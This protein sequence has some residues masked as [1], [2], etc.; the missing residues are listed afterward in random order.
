MEVRRMNLFEGATKDSKQVS[1]NQRACDQLQAAMLK[2]CGAYVEP[3]GFSS[4]YTHTI[5]NATKRQ[6]EWDY[7]YDIRSAVFQACKSDDTIPYYNGWNVKVPTTDIPA[8]GIADLRDVLNDPKRLFFSVT[9]L[10][11]DAFIS[12]DVANCLAI[13]AAYGSELHQ[14]LVAVYR[15][16]YRQ[17][18]RVADMDEYTRVDVAKHMEGGNV[19]SLIP[20][21]LAEFVTMCFPMAGGDPVNGLLLVLSPLKDVQDVVRISKE[22]G[23]C[24]YTMSGV[25]LRDERIDFPALA[26]KVVSPEFDTV[27]FY[28]EAAF[29]PSVYASFSE[30]KVE[31]D[32][33]NAAVRQHLVDKEKDDAYFA[34]KPTKRNETRKRFTNVC[35][36]A[37]PGFDITPTEYV[38]NPALET[39]ARLQLAEKLLVHDIADLDLSATAALARSYGIPFGVTK[40]ANGEEAFLDD[41][42][43]NLD[44]DRDA[45][46]YLCLVTALDS[47]IR[48]GSA[49]GMKHRMNSHLGYLWENDVEHWWR[50][51][52]CRGYKLSYYL[53][54]INQDD[55]HFLSDTEVQVL[56]QSALS[57]QMLEKVEREAPPTVMKALSG[58]IVH[59]NQLTDVLMKMIVHLKDVVDPELQWKTVELCGPG[60]GYW[61]SRAVE[62]F[63]EELK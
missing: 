53:D 26:A 19:M 10:N 48:Y 47:L 39:A 35:K 32:S 49:Y 30:Y 3:T 52:K 2:E 1:T 21:W 63:L 4:E 43:V 31:R 50:G 56:A 36:C 6:M 25:R 45:M 59:R 22:V 18:N 41:L 51:G 14:S 13:G 29:V 12:A 37:L 8:K 7:G 20:D 58:I 15:L 28:D 11:H 5:R 61:F 16:T 57:C 23:G 54:H 46:L 33:R 40:G 34:S 38:E 44:E 17:F 27:G 24:L 60:R 42:D 62:M 55:V 9:S